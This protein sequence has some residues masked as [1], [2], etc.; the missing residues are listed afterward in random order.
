VEVFL[1]CCRRLVEKTKQSLI[2]FDLDG[3][4][5]PPK[6]EIFLLTDQ[7]FWSHELLLA[8]RLKGSTTFYANRLT[9]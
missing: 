9:G 8:N 2:E 1:F 7:F 5:F 6:S 4:L 3:F